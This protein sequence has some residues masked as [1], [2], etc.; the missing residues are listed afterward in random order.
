MRS[1]HATLFSSKCIG[2]PTAHPQTLP[3]TIASVAAVNCKLSS[4]VAEQSQW[5][6][7]EKQGAPG[8]EITF[9][10]RDLPRLLN[11][12]EAQSS[13]A[14]CNKQK[15]SQPSLSFTDSGNTS[16][17]RPAACFTRNKYGILSHSRSKN[18]TRAHDGT[19][20]VIKAPVQGRSHL[21]FSFESD[22]TKPS[23]HEETSFLH[24]ILKTPPLAPLS[25]KEINTEEQSDGPDC[26]ETVV[27]DKVGSGSHEASQEESTDLRELPEHP[28]VKPRLFWG[29]SH[30][31]GCGKTSG[32]ACVCFCASGQNTCIQ[33]P[34]G[35]S[36]YEEYLLYV[37]CIEE[38][39][40][41]QLHQSPELSTRGDGC[42]SDRPQDAEDEVTVNDGPS[43]GVDD[44]DRQHQQDKV[45]MDKAE[46][47]SDGI[48][49]SVGDSGDTKEMQRAG[50]HSQSDRLQRTGDRNRTE[51]LHRR[52]AA[53]SAEHHQN[54]ES[55][56][57]KLYLSSS[58]ELAGCAEVSADEM[59]PMAGGT[60]FLPHSCNS[61]EGVLKL[62]ENVATP[63]HCMTTGSLVQLMHLSLMG[64]QVAADGQEDRRIAQMYSRSKGKE[65]QAQW[66]T[67]N[68]RAGPRRHWERSSPCWSPN[69]HTEPLLRSKHPNRPSSSSSSVVRSRSTSAGAKLLNTTSVGSSLSKSTQQSQSGVEKQPSQG[70]IQ[71]EAGNHK[72]VQTGAGVFV[73]W[74]SLPDEVWLS[75]LTLLPH[76]DLSRVARVCRQLCSLAYDR[77]LWKKVQIDNQSCLNDRS[78]SSIGRRGPQSLHLFRCTSSCITSRGLDDL[79]LQCKGSLKELTITSCSGPGFQGDDILLSCSRHCTCLTAIDVSWTGATDVG[80]TALVT[81]CVRLETVVLNG[82]QVTDKALMLLFKTHGRSLCRLEVFGCLSLGSECLSALMEAS[83]HMEVL[84]IGKIPKISHQCLVHMMSRFKRL[85][86]L[87]VTGLF[88]VWD[89]S[90]HHIVKQCP[91]LRS[92]TLSS[93]PRITDVSLIEISTYCPSIRNLDVSGC[94]A[95][96]DWGVQAIAMSCVHLQDLDLSQTSTGNK[97]VTLLANYCYRNLQTVKLSF[98]WISQEAVRKL[99]RHCKRLKLLHLYGCCDVCNVKELKA[100]NKE[101]QVKC[102][103]SDQQHT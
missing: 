39:K 84:N 15:L 18:G 96:T 74:L 76:V 30:H 57:A 66:P 27:A 2:C 35:L 32:K 100:I 101:V 47:E 3:V 12:S 25:D 44:D 73:P 40:S 79:F 65:P 75:I 91:N 1:D 48:L 16:S 41:R 87:N 77:T 92:L 80:I 11:E 61:Q 56:P 58:C 33:V 6:V 42:E 51:I 78:L 95:I 54:P 46:D 17:C 81:A 102:D 10:P 83:P 26:L 38:F 21:D 23:L 88:A 53:F 60:S 52:C 45:K 49:L 94:R 99:C 59:L 37:A 93:C 34:Q 70:C 4:P 13:F 72:N 90:V 28:K 103:C 69:V 50:S 62:K 68:G 89:Q 82:C 43:G 36:V 7:S 86:S 98:C 8:A 14:F 55:P 97:G 24:E 63:K 31:S 5:H 85:T 71:L 64:K 20:T 29:K 67:Q 9:V 22:Q 19:R